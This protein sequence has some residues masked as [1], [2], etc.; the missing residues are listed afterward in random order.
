MAKQYPKFIKHRI[1]DFLASA[2]LYQPFKAVEHYIRQCHAYTN[3]FDFKGTTFSYLCEFEKEIKTFELQLTAAS[4]EHFGRMP[5]GTIPKELFNSDGRL[6][7][8]EHFIGQCQ[9]CK[10][11]HI[12]FLLHVYTDKEIPE[13][14]SDTL[15]VDPD[16]KKHRPAD[17]FNEDRANLFIEK[18]GGPKIKPSI[19]KAFEKYL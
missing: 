11:F 9:S 12:D 15:R 8:E 16:T 6:D 7:F 10:D 18:I 19:P 1:S 5:G 13:D 2:P 14:Q 4:S 17:V 3:P